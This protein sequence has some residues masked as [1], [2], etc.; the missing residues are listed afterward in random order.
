MIMFP[1]GTMVI[2]PEGATVP[3]G[4]SH[5]S[6]W[7]RV[8]AGGMSTGRIIIRTQRMLLHKRHPRT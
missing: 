1:A 7:V 8:S 6:M 5:H 2:I 3:P 4:W